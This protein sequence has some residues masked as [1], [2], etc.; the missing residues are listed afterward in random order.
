[1]N[2]FVTS[3]CPK[4]SAAALDDKRVVKMV[5]ESAQMLSTAINEHG[6]VAP[7][8]STHKNHPANVWARATRANYMWL[9]EHF[10]A[11]CRE[12][13][14]RYGKVH[15]CESYVMDFKRLATHIPEG[16]I[17]MFANCAANASI[18]VSFKDHADVFEA[19]RKYLNV[20]WQNDKREPNW[21]NNTEPAW[22]QI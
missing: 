6:G 21:K 20:R 14:E 2:I 12:Y 4:K 16:T 13:T 18:G 22:R 17:T 1:M 11:L 3:A 5:L 10:I 15:K 19:Y 8:K 9:Y 7:Y